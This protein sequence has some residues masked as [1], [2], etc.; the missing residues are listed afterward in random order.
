MTTSSPPAKDEDIL[1]RNPLIARLSESDR[2][3][4]FALLDQIAITPKTEIIAE[5]SPGETMYFVLEGR[6]RA[7]R[8]ALD[9]GEIR[10]GDHFGELS[11]I[12]PRR[13]AA[14]VHAETTCRLARLSRARY[15]TLV[16]T[17]PSAAINLLQGLIDYLA[18]RLVAM[19]DNVDTLLRSRSLP[20][21]THLTVTIGDETRSV[22]T[23]TPLGALV[24]SPD[25]A[26][27]TDEPVGALVDGK[28][29]SLA[30]ALVSD[31][32]VAPLP[33]GHG[34][35]LDIYLRSVQLALLEASRRA[36]G[37]RA[38]RC[39]PRIDAATVIIFDDHSTAE[40]TSIARR[41]RTVYDTLRV[42]G[43]ELREE[44]WTT[45]EAEAHFR[46]HGDHQTASLLATRREATVPLVTCGET[47][48]YRTGP[49]VGR[50]SALDEV[51]FREHPDGLLVDLGERVRSLAW[52]G[53]HA[54][55]LS[56]ELEATTP[57]FGGD[58]AKMHVGWLRGMGVRCVGDFNKKCVSGAVDEIIR[59]AEG[60]HEKRIGEIA[61]DIAAGIGH[62][63]I[64]C[65]AGPSSS[66]KTSFIKRL[67]VQL[68]IHGIVPFNVSLDDYYVDRERT[69]RDESGEL[70]FEAPDA[71]D[72]RLLREHV[73]ALLGGAEVRTAKY[74][75]RT[76]KSQPT[77]GHTR[78][79]DERGLLVLEGIHGLNASLL[80]GVANDDIIRRIFIHPATTL[81]FDRLTQLDPA[82]LRLIRRI[83]R[84]RH[85]RG[86]SAADNIMRWASVRRGEALHIYPNLARADAV[87]DSSL[88]YELSVLKVYAERY[89]LEVEP[90]HN[91]YPT[92]HRL[93]QLL[94]HFVTI[95]PDHVPSTSIVREFIG[96]SSFD[97]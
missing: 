9:L 95:Y 85:Q 10:P 18:N 68:Q 45:D 58:M 29:T 96:G 3:A 83:V 21:R 28:P 17:A 65:I 77:G 94:D 53:E 84:D 24:G 43:E 91:A 42:S 11:M 56:I 39:G 82:D 15:E 40:R 69:P 80:E 93:R 49:V 26:D 41:L 1:A 32:I 89:L 71:I 75:F 78:S 44:L 13:R 16:K 90:G 72:G 81:A 7:A 64:I 61:D 70:D 62:L 25:D 88:A 46:A 6:L 55:E 47:Y 63:R 5:G 73:A 20:R 27:P 74:D 8:S 92:A 50:A 87:F 67:M 19:T 14:S 54:A 22:A 86:F 36:F 37:G 97:Y 76:G 52:G 23:G 33:L 12:A 79:L 60:F 66:G 35:G 34:A 30:T 4:L 2:A 51:H 48:A 38:F 59:V 31:A 57:R